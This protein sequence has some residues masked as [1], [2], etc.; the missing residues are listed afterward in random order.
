MIY[1]GSAE[2]E[3][4]DQILDSIFVGPVPIGVNKFDFEV[5]IV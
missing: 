2:N 4:D 3:Q 1:V 5:I